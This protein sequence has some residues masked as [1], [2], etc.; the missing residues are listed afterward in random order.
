M[1]TN[2][3]NNLENKKSNAFVIIILILIILGAIALV[4]YLFL[5]KNKL[6][7]NNQSDISVEKNSIKLDNTKDYV[8]DAE[9]KYNSK[10]YRY[11]RVSKDASTDKKLV[12]NENVTLKDEYLKV[13]EDDIP[14][15][16]NNNVQ[17]LKDLKV[18][19]ININSDDAKKVNQELENLYMEYAEEFDESATPDIGIMT[20]LLLNYKKYTNGNVISIVVVDGAQATAPWYFQYHTYNFD[21]T[22][23]KLLS[24]KDVYTKAGIKESDIDKKTETAITNKLKEKY[25]LYKLDEVKDIKEA[26]F[27][28]LL[29]ESLAN[30]KKELQNNTFK[31]YLGENGK[32]FVLPLYDLPIEN[33]YYNYN[34]PVN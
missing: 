33:Q 15:Q 26:K 12:T 2:I 22:T 8:Y 3:N 28:Y 14:F 30:Y 11:A 10:Y 19:Y 31:Y 20:H 9:Y 24:Y 4:C 5:S 1:D 7:N 16:V 13:N 32:L 29:K 23:G 25:N 6:E 34:T 17:Y 21:I 27:D 18:P